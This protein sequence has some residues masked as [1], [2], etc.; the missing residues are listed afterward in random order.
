[1][2]IRKIRHV[3]LREIWP[4]EDTDFTVWLEDNIDYL[5]D[6]LGFDITVEQREKPVGPFSLDLYGEDANGG[7]VII[8]N[9][10]EKTDHDHLGKVLTYMSN[11]EGKKAIWISPTPREEH[12]RAID[13]LNEF[14]PDDIAFYLVKLEAIRI[15]DHPV[16]APQFTVVKGPSEEVKQI[17]SEKKADAKRHKARESFWTQFIDHMNTQNDLYTNIS[18]TFRQVLVRSMGV[19]GVG[20]NVYCTKKYVRGE[21][22]MSKGKREENKSI[23]DFL[24]D[25]RQQIEAAYGGELVWERLDQGIHTRIKHQLDDVD[26][27]NEKDWPRIMEFLSDSTTRFEQAFRDPIKQY[28]SQ[29]LLG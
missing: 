21:I 15:G 26:W 28:K 14:T 25:Q 12:A 16:V 24:F 9:Q 11:L 29:A 7:K 2:Q 23:F 19:T 10:L 22:Y 17:G 13:W 5:N 20:L 27:T 6:A 8:E 18:P 4:R 1:M 3:P